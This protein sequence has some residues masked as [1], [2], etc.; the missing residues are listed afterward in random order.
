MKTFSGH[1]N[2]K[3]HVTFDMLTSESNA[4]H[5]AH[6]YQELVVVQETEQQK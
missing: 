2:S 1:Y 4:I 6:M 3:L 5:Q